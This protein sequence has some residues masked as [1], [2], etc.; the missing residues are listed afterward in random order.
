[1][2]PLVVQG[3]GALWAYCKRYFSAFGK[4]CEYPL[5]A[6]NGIPQGCASRSWPATP[7]LKGG[8]RLSAMGGGGRK[9][10]I[11]DRYVTATQ[12]EQLEESARE[13]FRWE[14]Q[15]GWQ[16]NVKKT[17]LAS[18]PPLPQHEEIGG[19][20]IVKVDTLTSLGTEVPLHGHAKLDLPK[21]RHQSAMCALTRVVA[22]RLPTH[23]IQQ[24][25]EIVIIP[26]TC[27]HVQARPL[28]DYWCERLRRAIHVAAGLRHKGHC[29]E[30]IAALF[31]RAHRYDPKCA[32]CLLSLGFGAFGFCATWKRRLSSGGES[33]PSDSPLDLED[34]WGLEEVPGLF[35]P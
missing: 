17:T 9:S 12:R 2:P 26:K 16:T 13:G 10:Y 23:V 33:M 4:I 14:Q 25:V 35:G 1:M 15:N 19:K 11:D 5:P 3:L 20:S 24:L 27:Y 28:Q 8:W 6:C 31:R 22:L 34:L 29:Y 7:W 32:R 21:K 18:I 30:V